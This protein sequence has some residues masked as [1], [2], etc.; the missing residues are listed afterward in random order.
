MT[1]SQ[2]VDVLRKL[3]FWAADTTQPEHET[4]ERVAAR[5]AVAELVEDRDALAKALRDILEAGLTGPGHVRL[6]NAGCAA[7]TRVQGE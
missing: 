7:L 3:A 5:V 6:F 1:S 4:K 2:P